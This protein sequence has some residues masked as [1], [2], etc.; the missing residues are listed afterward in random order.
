MLACV[1][2][3]S[4]SVAR[5]WIGRFMK[6]RARATIGPGMVETPWLQ[7]GLGEQYDARRKSFRSAT[8]LAETIQPE[9]VADAAYW[10]CAGARKTT[11][12]FLLVDGHMET[13]A[14]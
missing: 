2:P 7:N 12:E 13:G 5:M 11:G 14:A 6:R 4:G 9:D 3:S 8:P 1:R 10:L